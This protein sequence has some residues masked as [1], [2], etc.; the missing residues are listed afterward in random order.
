MR[1]SHV[2]SSQ[3]DYIDK[4]VLDAFPKLQLEITGGLGG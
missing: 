1:V 3:L 4:P 2:H